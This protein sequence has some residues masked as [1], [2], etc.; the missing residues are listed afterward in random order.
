MGQQRAD[1]DTG[2]MAVRARC[3][4]GVDGVADLGEDE[5][6]VEYVVRVGAI[7]R[8]EFCGNREQARAQDFFEPSIGFGGRQRH[9]ALRLGS[10]APTRRRDLVPAGHQ[11]DPR[12]ASLELPID[13]GLQDM[14]FI[15]VGRHRLGALEGVHPD[16]AHLGLDLAMAVCAHA[17][18]GSISK[19]LRAGHRTGHARRVENALATHLA[20]ED[21]SLRELL[22]RVEPTSEAL[23]PM[24]RIANLNF[25]A[26]HT[27]RPVARCEQA[28]VIL[29]SACEAASV[30]G[31]SNRQPLLGVEVRAR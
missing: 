5:R 24:M 13:R 26:I 30:G 16:T 11:V 6:G 9:L 27:I 14:Q 25:I 18:T 21:P 3:V 19:I 22:G 17:S 31:S 2:H 23:A 10:V 20:I 7:R 4:R 29:K 15:F 1:R 8:I 28:R 12:R